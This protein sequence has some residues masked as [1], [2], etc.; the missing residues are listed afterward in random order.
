M[1]GGVG[2]RE[3]G[4][5]RKSLHTVQGPPAFVRMVSSLPWAWV[6]QVALGPGSGAVPGQD[7]DGLA[8]ISASWPSGPL[9]S[10]AWQASPCC[11]VA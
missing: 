9:S 5:Q 8:S 2:R 4:T 3:E 6:S 11:T 10:S 7:P 1:P